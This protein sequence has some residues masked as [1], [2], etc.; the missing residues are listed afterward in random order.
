MPEMKRVLVD[1][2]TKAKAANCCSGIWTTA[3]VDV[4]DFNHESAFD[5]YITMQFYHVCIFVFHERMRVFP[6]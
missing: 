5:L 6:G 3:D 4:F 2:W 1:A